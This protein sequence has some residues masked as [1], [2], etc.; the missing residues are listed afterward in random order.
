[1]GPGGN[2]EAPRERLPLCTRA[3]A[4]G[5]RFDSFAGEHAEQLGINGTAPKPSQPL[6][7]PSPRPGPPSWG[8]VEGW[9]LVDPDSPP[10]Q[11]WSRCL[12]RY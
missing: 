10:L 11:A 5:D 7:A 12:V 9:R 8:L 2:R 6:F 4:R 1:M 3:H